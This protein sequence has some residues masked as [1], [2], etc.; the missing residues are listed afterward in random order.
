[1]I[2][3]LYKQV[4]MLVSVVGGV[5]VGVI[6]KP[7]WK[8]TAREDEAP[9]SGRHHGTDAQRTPRLRTRNHRSSGA[10]GLAVRGRDRDKSAR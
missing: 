10:P 4:S 3:L 7:V 2:R 1:M 5:L 6:F 9:A 8:I